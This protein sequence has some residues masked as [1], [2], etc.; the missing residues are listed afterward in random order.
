MV[1]QGEVFRSIRSPWR[2]FQP[3]RWFGWN[4]SFE[5]YQGGPRRVTLADVGVL[6]AGLISEPLL[7]GMRSHIAIL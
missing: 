3:S 2:G 6:L 7:G 5:A 1:T 4:P